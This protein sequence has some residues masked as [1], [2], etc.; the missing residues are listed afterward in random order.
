VNSPFD[1]R[2][3][4]LMKDHKRGF[5]SLVFTHWLTVWGRCALAAL[6]NFEPLCR[7]TACQTLWLRASQ[8]STRPTCTLAG[9]WNVCRQ[10]T[11]AVQPAVLFLCF[12]M[13]C[14]STHSLAAVTSV[15]RLVCC[16]ALDGSAA[17]CVLMKAC[18]C[19]CRST[20]CWWLGM[21]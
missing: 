21:T 6:R 7:A 14:S 13:H 2:S 1:S 5:A 12:Y 18:H 17:V 9:A 20:S 8:T 16:G 3:P 11:L 10:A 4:G 19:C 15:R